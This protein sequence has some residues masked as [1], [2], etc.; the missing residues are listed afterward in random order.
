MSL[1]GI[2][3][4]GSGASGAVP[5]T[6]WV[7]NGHQSNKHESGSVKWGSYWYYQKEV[8]Q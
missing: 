3:R 7:L 6:N 4:Q 8:E 2:T 1:P 5:G